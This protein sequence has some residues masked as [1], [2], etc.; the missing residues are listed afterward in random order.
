MRCDDKQI[1]A[2]LAQADRLWLFLDYDGTLADFAATPDL[3]EADLQL[4]GLLAALARQPGIRLAI[5]SG[6]R[7]S[8]IRALLKA[9]GVLLAGTYGIEFLSREDNEIHRLDFM[10]Y[11]PALEAVK[12][13]LESLLAGRPGFY[14]EDKGWSLALHA[15]FA[16]EDE[17]EEVIETAREIFKQ[18]K[19]LE[20]FRLLGGHK[21]LEI[22]PVTGD[23]GETV[24]YLLDQYPW[25][26]ALPVYLGDDERDEE[27]FRVIV[28]RGGIA[29]RVGAEERA[30][31]AQCRL[32]NPEAVRRWLKKIIDPGK[33]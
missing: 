18:A 31:L 25:P 5:V 30:S 32:E 2:R 28:Q 6:R 23:K 12:P 15:R 9:P 19:D 7:L 24:A 1:E 10:A 21:F 14:L 8:H 17:A 26:G 16:E 22:C 27:A 4:A 11:R 33:T 20:N 29:I 3:I 13:A